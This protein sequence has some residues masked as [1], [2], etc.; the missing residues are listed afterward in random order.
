M[1][2]IALDTREEAGRTA[3]NRLIGIITDLFQNDSGPGRRLLSKQAGV[4]GPLRNVSW[5]GPASTVAGQVVDYLNSYGPLERRS[6][7]HA[8]GAFLDYLLTLPDVPSDDRFF[9]A[10]LIISKNLVLDPIYMQ[11]LEKQYGRHIALAIPETVIA[12]R[13]RNSINNLLSLDDIWGVPYTAQAVARIEVPEGIARG[14]GFLIGPDL[15]L[16]NQH[17]LRSRA[18]VQAARAVFSYQLRPARGSNM[19]ALDAGFY[20]SSPED[21]LDY[22]LVRVADRPLGDVAVGAAADSQ[23][24]KDLVLNGVHRGYLHCD[25]RSIVELDRINILQHAEGLAMKAAL[26]SNRV[27]EVISSPAARVRYET[28]TQEGSSGSPGLSMKW[29]V[30]AL[31]KGTEDRPG[32]YNVGVPITAILDDLQAQATREPALREALQGLQPGF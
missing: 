14:T 20:Y 1:S 21:E 12:E 23:N 13:I 22:A 25:R 2:N 4:D 5:F 16:T 19:L 28:D 11:R 17:V 26:T 10:S 9:L 8:L 32:G 15:L 31:H 3:F 29:S 6:H 27:A 24:L 18:E 30:L 7:F